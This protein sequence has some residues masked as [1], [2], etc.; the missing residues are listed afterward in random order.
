MALFSIA[1]CQTNAYVG[2]K[3]TQDVNQVSDRAKTDPYK[4]GKCL[5]VTKI[6]NLPKECNI[7]SRA[8]KILGFV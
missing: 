5:T 6:E 1:G 3:E 2:A 7:W 4:W 8:G